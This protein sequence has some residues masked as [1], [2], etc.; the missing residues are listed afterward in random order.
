MSEYNDS[1]ITGVTSVLDNRTNATGNGGRRPSVSSPGTAAVIGC[2]SVWPG[3]A[4][5]AA[6]S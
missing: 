5:A 1:V 3:A 2:G 4:A 6:R